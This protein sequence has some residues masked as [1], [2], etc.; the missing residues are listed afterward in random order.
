[1]TYEFYRDYRIATERHGT[2][3]R[4]MIRPPNSDK[5]IPGPSND[6]PTSYKTVLV[7]AKRLIDRGAV[8]QSTIV[9]PVLTG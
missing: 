8:L 6:D 5:L 1:M 9:V 4:A 7:E 2:G 3:W